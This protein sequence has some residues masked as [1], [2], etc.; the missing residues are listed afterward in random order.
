MTD[1]PI[2]ASE[3]VTGRFRLMT[4]K[5]AIIGAYQDD[6]EIT[7]VCDTGTVHQK[8]KA[9]FRLSDLPFM[10]Y[11]GH[12]T[13]PVGFNVHYDGEGEEAWIEIARR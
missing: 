6:R 7:V 1:A 3:L 8:F 9:V 11:R 5:S 12:T 4:E 2:D 10:G 13:D